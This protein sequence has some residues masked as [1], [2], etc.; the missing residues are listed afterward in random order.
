MNTLQRPEQVHKFE[1][2]S[3]YHTRVLLEYFTMVPTNPTSIKARG[4]IIINRSVQGY[5]DGVTLLTYLLTPSLIGRPLDRSSWM[6]WWWCMSW[7]QQ[8]TNERRRHQ[9]TIPQ[10][11]AIHCLS[12]PPSLPLGVAVSEWVISSQAVTQRIRC[13]LCVL[14][15]YRIPRFWMISRARK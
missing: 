9:P 12:F 15:L 6:S 2:A 11:S 13:C 8:R 4:I 1:R 5:V 7:Q 10:L 3:E 14:S